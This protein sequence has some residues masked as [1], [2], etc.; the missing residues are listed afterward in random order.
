MPC[1]I[2]HPPASASGTDAVTGFDFPVLIADIGGTNARFALATDAAAEPRALTN[3]QTADFANFESAAEAALAPCGAR[4]QSCIACAAGPVER[5]RV[6][7]TNA[8]WRM[9]GR[10]AAVALGLKSGL[11]LNDFEA[12][13]LSIPVFE[14][15]WLRDIGNGAPTPGGTRVIH[16]P[17][18]GLGTA[19]LIEVDGKWRAVAS[20]G[21]HSDFAPVYPDE[22]EVWPHLEPGLGRVTPESLIS[23]P[24]LTRLHEAR[25]AASK[26]GGERLAP[27][28]IIARA[29]KDPDCREADTVRMFWRLQARYAG[30]VALTFL[31]V[32]GVYLAGG[33]L[34]RIEELLDENE[35]RRAFENKAPYEALSARIPVRLLKKADAVIH[36]MTAIARAPHRYAIDYAERAWK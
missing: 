2:L 15:S 17:G 6:N 1:A 29:L 3:L 36:G 33:V 31:A 10:A 35:F 14:T 26:T 12:L 25:L 19:A 20:E 28:Q 13:A 22:R 4:P 8:G 9:E 11:F 30:D 24:G 7:L 5:T 18:T 21:S 16:G 32:G 34:P 23:G 27:A